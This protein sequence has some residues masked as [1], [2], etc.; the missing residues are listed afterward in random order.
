MAKY[1]PFPL[2][3]YDNPLVTRLSPFQ[4][5]LFAILTLDYWKTGIPLPETDKDAVEV[6]KTD[7]QKWHLNKDKVMLAVKA[8]KPMLIKARGETKKR[9]EAK[10]KIA[11]YALSCRKYKKKGKFDAISD[12]S[13]NHTAINPLPEKSEWKPGKYDHVARKAA[14]QA[15]KSDDDTM[16]SDD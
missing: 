10:R 8:V 5:G 13:S 4:F 14:I 9:I 16:L 1:L 2:E 3:I 12:D 15:N 6:C 11:E 7:Y